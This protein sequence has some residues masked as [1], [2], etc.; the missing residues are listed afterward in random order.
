[1]KFSEMPYQRVVYEAIEKRYFELIEECRRAKDKKELKIVFQKKHE[2]DDDLTDMSLCYVRHDMDVNDSFYAEEQAYYDEIS[3]K[4]TELD[5]QFQNVL[6]DTTHRKAAE[7]ILGP[8]VMAMMENS[9]KGFHE[10]IIELVQEEN[11]LTGKH[12]QLTST[13]VVHWQ[14]KELKRSLMTPYIQAKERNTRKEASLAC[15]ASWEIQ[16]DKLEDL[17]G[18]LVH[19]RDRQAK[20]LGYPSYVELSYCR[21]NRIGYTPDDVREFR[22]AVKQELVPLLMKMENDRKERL[23]LDYLYY[24]DNGISFKDGNP[25]PK[26]DTKACLEAT[27]EMYHSLSPETAEFIDYVMDNELYDVEIRSGKRGGG[28]MMSLERYRAPFI[29]ANFDGTSENAYIMTHEGGHA[30]QYYL[31]REEKVREQSW[32]NS[33]IAETHAMAMEFFTSPY[34]DLFFGE[35]AEDYRTLHLAKA[36]QLIAYECEQDEF[37]EIVYQNPDMTPDERNALW[38]CLEQEYMPFRDYEGDKN[39]QQGCGWQRIQHIFQWPFYAIDY[40]LAQVCALQYKCMMEEA[41]ERAW[42]S[43]L[44]FCKKSGT[45]NFTKLQEEAGLMNPFKAATLKKIADYLK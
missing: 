11:I 8:Q 35:R 45:M 27:R 6:L 38:R 44:I 30:F 9:I 24:Y 22:E 13:A 33:E 5:N 1:M 28:Y 19:N 26:G 16:R 17:F 29:F 18:K 42:Q 32:L 2:L 25:L 41:P 21:M 12:N 3:P 31:K 14:G 36:L 37:Q 23:G 15:S 7:D 10:S 43:Y 34:M 39:L 4:L 20:Q 40:A